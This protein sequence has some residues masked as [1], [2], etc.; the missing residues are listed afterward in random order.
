M[1]LVYPRPEVLVSPVLH[2]AC[3]ETKC[4]DVLRLLQRSTTC[5]GGRGGVSGN[6]AATRPGINQ[7]GRRSDAQV[8]MP[9]LSVAQLA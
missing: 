1:A 8:A 9:P 7:A 5:F 2:L 3:S 4:L 6:S